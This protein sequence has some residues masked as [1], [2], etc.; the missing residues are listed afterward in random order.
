MD[1]VLNVFVGNC[2]LFPVEPSK[3]KYH[4]F[5]LDFNFFEFGLCITY[6]HPRIKRNVVVRSDLQALDGVFDL[7][8][9]CSALIDTGENCFGFSEDLPTEPVEFFEDFISKCF[10]WDEGHRA[11][12]VD[13]IVKVSLFRSGGADPTR[14]QR[15]FCGVRT[16]GKDLCVPRRN[17]VDRLSD[18]IQNFTSKV[19]GRFD[20]SQCFVSGPSIPFFH[21]TEPLHQRSCLGVFVP[22]FPHE[23]DG[24]V[25]LLQGKLLRPITTFVVYNFVRSVKFQCLSLVLWGNFLPRG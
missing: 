9:G 17:S 21:T 25:D 5:A 16:Q 4:I 19:Q 15:G 8:N 1:A 10:G 7:G 12:K 2:V 20:I 13:E 22:L 23:L 11:E 14:D 18:M 6:N 3:S 24:V